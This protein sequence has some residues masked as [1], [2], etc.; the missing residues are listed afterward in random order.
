MTK[1]ID[2]GPVA[3]GHTGKGCTFI[4]GIRN[5][6]GPHEKCPEMATFAITPFGLDEAVDVVCGRHLTPAVREISSKTNKA[7]I[8]QEIPVRQ[9]RKYR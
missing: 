7:L 1:A 9:R 8:V 4:T 5:A 6:N 2:Y 3:T